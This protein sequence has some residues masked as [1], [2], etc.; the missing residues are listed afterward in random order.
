M[1]NKTDASLPLSAS[2]FHI[3]LV[4]AQQ[5]LYGYAILNAVVEESGGHVRP[6]LGALYRALARLKTQGLV[7]EVSPPTD[8]QPAPGHKRRYFGLADL[9]HRVLRAETLRLGEVVRL[10][11]TR[12]GSQ[13]G[14]A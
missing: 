11:E 6:D 7:Q 1:V 3:L 13:G 10:A 12:L 9:G 14:A 2:D 4:L 5:E 8:A